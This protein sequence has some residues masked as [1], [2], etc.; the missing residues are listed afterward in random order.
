MTLEKLLRRMGATLSKVGDLIDPV[1]NNW[2]EDLIRQT[3]CPIDVQRI[4]SNPL[5]QYDMPDFVAWSTRKMV[6]FRFGLLI[7]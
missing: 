5:S 6:C 1:L 3:M 4:L 2:D 7:L